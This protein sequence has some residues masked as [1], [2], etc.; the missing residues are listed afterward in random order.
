M[1]CLATTANRPAAQSLVLNSSA[2]SLRRLLARAFHLPLLPRSDTPAAPL[3]NKSFLSSTSSRWTLFTK[4]GGSASAHS[5]SQASAWRQKT[6]LT[7]KQ[8]W[9]G[10]LTRATAPQRLWTILRR[11]CLLLSVADR[12][13][14]RMMSAPS[15]TLYRNL[16]EVAPRRLVSIRKCSHAWIGASHACKHMYIK[17]VWLDGWDVGC[18]NCP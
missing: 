18:D 8:R 16:S 11:I 10:V 2:G 14:S 1:P 6:L 7:F 17:L 13:N 12:G 9:N 15:G 5:F 3:P 4:R